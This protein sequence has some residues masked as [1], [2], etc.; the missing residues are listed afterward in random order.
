[1]IKR[2]IFENPIPIKKIYSIIDNP[3]FDIR[4]ETNDKVLDYFDTPID[5]ILNNE[6]D[7][8]EVKLHE[9]FNHSE[10]NLLGFVYALLDEENDESKVSAIDSSGLIYSFDKNSLFDYLDEF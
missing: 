1:M 5:L 2:I 10:E 7:V 9:V 4:E 3:I 6:E 8:I